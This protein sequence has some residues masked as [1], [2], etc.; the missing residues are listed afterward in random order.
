MKN[1]DKLSVYGI[2]HNELDLLKREEFVKNFRPYSVF[3]DIIE[4]NLVTD[5]L[6]LSTCLRNEFYFWEA[7]DNIKN[8]F[9]EVEGLFV[10]HGK[11]ALIHLLKVSCGFDSSIPGEEQILAQVK[12]AY[13]DKIEKGERPSPLN[14]IF[15]KAI[16][17]GKKFRTMSKINENSISVEAL[18][19]KEAE[20]EFGDLSDKKIFIV[21]AG[22]IASSLVKILKKKSCNNID[23]IKRRKSMIEETVNYFSFDDKYNLFYDADIVFSSTSAPHLIFELNEMNTKKIAD[24]KRLLIDFAV[25]RDIENLIGQ[26]ENQKLINLEELNNLAIDSYGKRCQICEEY[27]WIIDFGIEKILEWFN[28]RKL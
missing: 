8:Q 19:I 28:R 4:D 24:K 1:L 12:K 10:K 22:E 20:K 27:N 14:T 15:N 17:L 5:G 23:V 11:D 25:P 18:G 3:R 21:G 13:I 2:N 16:A 26:Q 6:L 9:Q 7:K